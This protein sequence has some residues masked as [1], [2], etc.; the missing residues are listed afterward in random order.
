MNTP[1]QTVLTNELKLHDYRG[2]KLSLTFGDADINDGYSFARVNF[3]A[4]ETKFDF[5]TDKPIFNIVADE[6]TLNDSPVWTISNQ[7][8]NTGMNADMIDGLHAYELKDRLGRHHFYHM[9]NNPSG[10]KYVKI[11]TLTPRIIGNAPDFNSAGTKPFDGI[12]ANLELQDKIGEFKS[13]TVPNL[14]ELSKNSSF[15]STD[16]QTEGVYNTTFR[17]TVT[18]LKGTTPTTADIHIGLFRDPLN[19]VVDG[20]ESLSKFFYVSLHGNN[21]PY[22][23]DTTIYQIQSR[24]AE[25]E[26]KLIKINDIVSDK[27]SR[28]ISTNHTHERPDID[29]SKYASPS[30]PSK[31]YAPLEDFPQDEGNRIGYGGYIDT[32]RLYHVGDTTETIDGVQVITNKFDLYIAIDSKAELHIQPYMTSNCILYNFE[33]PIVESKLPNRNYLRGTSI[34]D[35]RYAYKGHR[36]FNYEQRI[37]HLINEV[38]NLWD[39][40]DNYTVINQGKSNAKKVMM[41]DN[42]GKIFAAEDNFERHKDTRR[43]GSRVLATDQYKC[44]VETSITLQELGTLEGVTSNIQNQINNINSLIQSISNNLTN[45]DHDG[46]YSKVG[47]HH[48]GVYSPVGHNHSGAYSPVGHHHDDRYSPIG[49]SHR[50]D[51]SDPNHTHDDLYSKIGHKHD[52]DYSK[53]SHNHDDV[54]LKINGTA[55]NTN[56]VKGKFIYVQKDQPAGT[57]VGDIWISW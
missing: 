42:D 26:E 29:K 35:E 44:L 19:K 36:H 4:E 46:I 47:H 56:K 14:S 37:M 33:S 24:L 10:R 50:G 55:A 51:F 1:S 2:T 20:W 3:R 53:T 54:Y 5:L 41:T 22:I 28:A 25:A 45:H 8:P 6:L 49:H 32:F 34:Y 13:N 43:T 48:D 11:A 30:D 17:A 9:F 40:F 38:D 15:A 23:S 39:M 52:S 57:N 21:L 7:G 18:I 31:N 16:M 27:S 12:F